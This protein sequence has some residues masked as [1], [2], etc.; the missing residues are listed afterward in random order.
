MEDP[1]GTG[2]RLVHVE[3]ATLALAEVIEDLVRDM[4]TIAI[5]LPDAT[6]RAHELGQ[7]KRAQALARMLRAAVAETRRQSS[8]TLT[9]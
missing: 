5:N 9:T 8:G 2:E 7:V 4:E 1:Q 3:N 6:K